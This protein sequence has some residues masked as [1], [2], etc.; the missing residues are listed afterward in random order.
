MSDCPLPDRSVLRRRVR[1]GDPGHGKVCHHT[2]RHRITSFQLLLRQEKTAR[3]SGL[4]ARKLYQVL[5]TS[6]IPVVPSCA[7]RTRASLSVYGRGHD[8]DAHAASSS[9]SRST[10]GLGI[11]RGLRGTHGVPMA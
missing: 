4:D 1:D 11:G 3:D 7:G 8:V 2:M 5:R 10:S 9:I 6:P